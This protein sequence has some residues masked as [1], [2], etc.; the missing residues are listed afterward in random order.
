M[1]CIIKDSCAFF[2]NQM[3]MLEERKVIIRKRFCL[4]SY[5]QCARFKVYQ[6]FK[7]HNNIPL[8]LYPNDFERATTLIAKHRKHGW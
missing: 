6:H 8:D 3:R 2:T 7:S 5:E 4:S 1:A